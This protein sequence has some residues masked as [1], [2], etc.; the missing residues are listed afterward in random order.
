MA[1]QKIPGTKV[2]RLV[3]IICPRDRVGALSWVAVMNWKAWISL[4]NPFAN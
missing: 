4:K 1:N 3:P 2:G